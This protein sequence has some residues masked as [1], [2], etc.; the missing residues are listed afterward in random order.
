MEKIIFHQNGFIIKNTNS[1]YSLHFKNYNG[2]EGDNWPICSYDKDILGS[3]KFNYLYGY[4]DNQL[5]RSNF[6]SQYVGVIS[7]IN[8]IREYL[9]SCKVLGFDTEVLFCETERILPKI[10]INIDKIRNK[11]K[12]IGYDYGYPGEDYYSCVYNDVSRIVEMS[13]LQLNKYGL[14][15]TEEEIIEFISLR[16]E[17][18]KIY[19]KYAFELGEFI[20]YKLWKCNIEIFS[21]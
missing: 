17:L 8:F 20:I 19:P 1:D 11:L 18:E 10:S 9:E 7:D 13:H 6:D 14:F 12:F 15:D 4:L 16:N 5:M 2:I 21:S 3:E